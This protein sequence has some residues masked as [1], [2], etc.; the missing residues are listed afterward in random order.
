[1]FFSIKY[2]K[3][4]ITQSY[5]SQ[6]R[7]T[8]E[9]KEE[10]SESPNDQGYTQGVLHQLLQNLIGMISPGRGDLWFRFYLI[11]SPFTEASQWLIG[12]R[13][14]LQY[15]WLRFNPW[16]EKILWCSIFAWRIPRNRGAWQATVHGIAESRTWLSD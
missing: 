16:V 10:N 5:K 8:W 2:G 7:T 9:E 14:Y 1:M 13:I 15:R 12:L 3:L 4:G 6:R 11:P